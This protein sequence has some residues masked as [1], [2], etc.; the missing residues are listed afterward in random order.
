MQFGLVG[1]NNVDRAL[2]HQIEKFAPIAIHAERVRKRQRDLAA[3]VMCNRRCLEK[4]ILGV[5]RVPQIAF[6]IDKR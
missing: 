2:A 4:G 5:L 3:G 1:E 6:E